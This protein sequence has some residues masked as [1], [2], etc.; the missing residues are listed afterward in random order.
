M[1][2]CIVHYLAD[3]LALADI[4]KEHV[5]FTTRHNEA[6]VRWIELD[7]QISIFV[8]IRFAVRKL[9]RVLPVPNC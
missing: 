4:P 5:F 8:I 6:A 9:D 7:V 2:R 1:I 3:S